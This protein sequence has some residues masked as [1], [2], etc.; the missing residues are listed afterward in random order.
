MW[1]FPAW[2]LDGWV[3]LNLG[4]K[5]RHSMSKIL[6]LNQRKGLVLK[7]REGLGCPEG[8][9]R[10]IC[11]DGSQVEFKDFFLL[12]FQALQ[13]IWNNKILKEQNREEWVM[14]GRNIAALIGGDSQAVSTDGRMVWTGPS[15]MAHWRCHT[16]CQQ[17]LTGRFYYTT[18]RLP[19]WFLAQITNNRQ[20]QAGHPWDSYLDSLAHL[21]W[22]KTFEKKGESSM[23]THTGISSALPFQQRPFGSIFF[24]WLLFFRLPR[25]PNAKHHLALMK[26]KQKVKLLLIFS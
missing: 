21:F 18:T 15:Q 12:S 20:W 1:C 22:K 24:L 14:R 19:D 5:A 17:D 7:S 9:S 6:M 11:T 4:G 23:K 8:R 2:R 10:L 13:R 16:A 25:L 26:V 3:L